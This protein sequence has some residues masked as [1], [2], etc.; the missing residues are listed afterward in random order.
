MS[1]HLAVAVV[2]G[3]EITRGDIMK[4]LNDMGPQM[5][6]QFQSPEGINRVIDEM[7]NQELL[8]LDA[9]EN[10]FEKE[11]EFDQVLQATKVGLLKG[12]AFNKLISGVTVDEEELKMYFNDNKHLFNQPEM[13]KASHILVADENRAM[14]IVDE[15]EGGMDFEDAARSYSSCP[16]SEVGGALG[17][18]GRGQMVPEFEEAAFNME[19]GEIS[20]PVKTQ[21]GYHIIRLEERKEAKDASFD[22]SREEVEKQVILRKQ[23]AKYMEK[24]NSLKEVY[25]VEIK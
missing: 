18:F 13:V 1:E 10:N 24:I 22:D 4:F 5:A 9:V 6:M 3:K 25:K 16:S 23:E 2:N 21:F 11:E 15:L 7:V 17:E 14:E 8:Y 20:A 12:Y 19:L